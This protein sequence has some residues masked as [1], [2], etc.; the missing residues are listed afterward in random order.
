MPIPR[1]ALDAISKEKTMPMYT[2]QQALLDNYEN[3][4]SNLDDAYAVLDRKEDID[5][6]RVD[7][8]GCEYDIVSYIQYDGDSVTKYYTVYLPLGVNQDQIEEYMDSEV[9]E[10]YSPH[11]CYHCDQDW[12]CC[13]S[14]IFIKP[15]YTFIPGQVILLVKQWGYQNV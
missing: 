2:A 9:V 15:I 8:E 12:D 11:N 14:W 6:K 13:G 10:D 4:K 1:K 3:L 5:H 7:I